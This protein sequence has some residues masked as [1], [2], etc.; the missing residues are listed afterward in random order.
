[1][2]ELR[3]LYHNQY[4]FFLFLTKYRRFKG[5]FD[6]KTNK[7]C[8]DTTDN[9]NITIC[10]A[11][12]ELFFINFNDE[13]HFENRFKDLKLKKITKYPILEIKDYK[14]STSYKPSEFIFSVDRKNKTEIL[15]GCKNGEIYKVFNSEGI[16]ENFDLN[17]EFNFLVIKY[18]LDFTRIE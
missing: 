13:K 12:K 7:I 5:S 11:P 1:G 16:V 14:S 17:Q 18:Q 15:Y 9:D 2:L 8:F 3:N 10:K 4:I 6:I